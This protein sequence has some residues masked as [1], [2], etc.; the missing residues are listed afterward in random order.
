MDAHSSSISVIP[1]V[2][3][4]CAVPLAPSMVLAHVPKCGA[5]WFQI[6]LHVSFFFFGS[7]LP[8]HARN[9]IVLGNEVGDE[10]NLL[11]T[12]FCTA[13]WNVSG[14]SYALFGVA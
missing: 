7:M 13:L 14:F 2:A 3:I 8:G 4:A 10:N 6:S 5:L 9:G 1:L 11:S 12:P